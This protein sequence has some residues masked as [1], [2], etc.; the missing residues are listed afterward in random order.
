MPGRVAEGWEVG[1]TTIGKHRGKSIKDVVVEDPRW[2][3]WAGLTVR[4]LAAF[5]AA[6]GMSIR[7]T[8]ITP[9]NEMTVEM[10]ET[11]RVPQA[12]E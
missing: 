12:D 6:N 8:Y 2:I 11:E 3:A 1:M 7:V 9:G 4:P 10:T 5:L